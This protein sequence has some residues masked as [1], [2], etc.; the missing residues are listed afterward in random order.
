MLQADTGIFVEKFEHQSRHDRIVQATH[1]AKP[2]IDF[3]VVSLLYGVFVFL[4]GNL[5]KKRETTTPT[6]LVT[7]RAVDKNLT[8]KGHGSRKKV[9][10]YSS[11]AARDSTVLVVPKVA[12]SLV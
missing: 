9:D 3:N 1:H 6:G 12:I 5:Q 2:V 11:V 4:H 7:S 10:G 8:R